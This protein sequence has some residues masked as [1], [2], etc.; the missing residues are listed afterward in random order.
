MNKLKTHQAVGELQIA[1]GSDTVYY[2]NKK[3]FRGRFLYR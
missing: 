3:L 1:I 2:Y